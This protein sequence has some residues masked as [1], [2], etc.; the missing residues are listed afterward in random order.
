MGT[1]FKDSNATSCPTDK[2]STYRNSDDC[3]DCD[4]W[5]E[6]GIMIS[7]DFLPDSQE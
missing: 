1:D 3:C 2:K 5:N 6:A 4:Q 7:H